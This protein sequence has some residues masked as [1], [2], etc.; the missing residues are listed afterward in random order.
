[1]FTPE[2]LQII[3]FFM[4]FEFSSRTSKIFCAPKREHFYVSNASKRI[5]FKPLISTKLYAA[6]KKISL[7]FYKI[8]KEFNF[9]LNL[10][11]YFTQL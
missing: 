3:W 9:H 5:K 8:K 7:Q 1:M 10:L 4:F 11:F 2:V 6:V